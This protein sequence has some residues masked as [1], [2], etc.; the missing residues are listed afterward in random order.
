MPFGRRP[1]SSAKRQKRIRS[2][3]WATAS[4][5]WPRERRLWAIS[6]KWRAAF[7]VICAGSIRGRSSSGAVKTS[8]S[9]ASASDGSSAARSSR[10]TIFTTGV[11]PVKFVWIS[12]RVDV[13]HDEQRRV[14]EVVLVGEQLDVGGLEVLV[15][16]LVLPGEEVALPDVGEAVPSPGLGD[17]LLEGVLGADRVGLVRRRLA[18]HPAEVDEVLLGA[19]LLRGRHAAPLLGE[20]GRGQGRLGRHASRSPTEDRVDPGQDQ[21]EL[22]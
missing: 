20:G 14:A 16:A 13:A 7:S 15:L 11:R 1:A 3:K 21:V 6:A 8:R 4:G 17:P 9:R 22:R 5:S 2:R 19:G 18:E 12:I 10:V